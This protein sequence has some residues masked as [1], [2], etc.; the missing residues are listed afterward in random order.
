MCV[1]SGSTVHQS[2]DALDRILNMTSLDES[3]GRIGELRQRWKTSERDQADWQDDVRQSMARWSL[4]RARVEEEIVRR[5]EASRYASPVPRFLTP[6]QSRERGLYRPGLRKEASRESLESGE[7]SG[8]ES[9][10]SVSSRR[11]LSPYRDKP[12]ICN[13]Y[14]PAG[15]PYWVGLKVFV[16]SL[17]FHSHEDLAIVSFLMCGTIVVLPKPES[18]GTFG[19]FGFLAEE[20]ALWLQVRQRPFSAS[21]VPDRR[22]TLN[23]ATNLV[24]A[25]K[26]RGIRISEERATRALLIPTD[27]PYEDCITRLPKPGAYLTARLSTDVSSRDKGKKSPKKGKKKGSGEKKKGTKKGKK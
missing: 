12:S 17:F 4:Q 10:C 24:S 21:A 26:R 20:G 11:S 16:D 8:N 13:G 3:E 25:F 19:L 1:P 5:Q 18:T 2:L 22:A 23:E 14:R 15:Q 9:D 27:K 6:E 7:S